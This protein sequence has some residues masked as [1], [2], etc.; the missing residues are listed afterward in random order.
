MEM[1]ALSG[2]EELAEHFGNLPPLLPSP[3]CLTPP[4]FHS[5]LDGDSGMMGAAADGGSAVHPHSSHTSQHPSSSL[6]QPVIHAPLLAS[7]HPS[8]CVAAHPSTH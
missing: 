1:R 4:T 2:R 3:P 7:S 8:R 6:M 5:G